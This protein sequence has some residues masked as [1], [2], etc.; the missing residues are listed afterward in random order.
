M[1]PNM[2]TGTYTGTGAAQSI[3]L[4]FK[5]LKVEIYNITDGD[6]F[7]VHYAGMTDA[8]H[9]SSAAAVALVSSNGITLS[10]TGFTVGTDNSVSENAKVFRYYA[11][12]D[13]D[14]AA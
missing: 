7:N 8:T 9:M 6:V 4:G 11:I 5:P 14:G 10:K 12:G 1:L 3:T 2:K 13:A